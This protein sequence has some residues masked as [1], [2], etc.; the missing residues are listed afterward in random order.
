[1]LEEKFR[2]YIT[3]YEKRFEKCLNK[4]IPEIE[5]NLVIIRTHEV[6]LHYFEEVKKYFE[7]N[8]TKR[9]INI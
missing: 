6:S 8:S 3:Q 4:E 9:Y 2:Y 1:M 5:S 7:N